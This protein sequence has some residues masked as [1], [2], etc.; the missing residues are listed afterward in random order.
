VI[1]SSYSSS[2]SSCSS[3]SAALFG[4]AAISGM[5]MGS[6]SGSGSGSGAGAALG[7]WDKLW[8]HWMR[9]K[10]G[11][12]VIGPSSWC[13]F[14]PFLSQNV[15]DE[16]RE[17]QTPGLRVLSHPMVH[18]FPEFLNLTPNDL[19]NGAPETFMERIEGT[20]EQVP[21]LCLVSQRTHVPIQHHINEKKIQGI[22]ILLAAF[23][24]WSAYCPSH[25][26]ETMSSRVSMGGT[27]ATERLTR[28]ARG[29]TSTLPL[30]RLW[31]PPLLFRRWKR[32][33]RPAGR[34]HNSNAH[35]TL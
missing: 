13:A 31:S 7:M 25:M 6:G 24:W 14:D 8:F 12:S 18:S 4:L 11:L 17:R 9:P 33:E 15:S 20:E 1:V 19:Q 34:S 27:R 35:K 21:P 23:R 10:Y 28:E 26:S 5:S 3:Y 16:K 22:F 32:Q 2:S 30:H 29:C